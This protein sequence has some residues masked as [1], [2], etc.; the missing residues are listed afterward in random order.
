MGWG[1]TAGVAAAGSLWAVAVAILPIGV[2]ALLSM[3]ADS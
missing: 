1:A 2:L 3:G